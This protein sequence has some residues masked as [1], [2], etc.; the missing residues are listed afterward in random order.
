MIPTDLDQFVQQQLACGEYCSQEEVVVAGLRILRELKR[1]KEEF[2]REVLVGVE[3][4]D[5]AEGIPVAAEELRAFF[6]DVQLRGRRR[7]EASKKA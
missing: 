7:Y 1:R 5:R 3:Q 2:R 4:L 6:D